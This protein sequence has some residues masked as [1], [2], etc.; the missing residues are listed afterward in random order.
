MACWNQSRNVY[1][2]EILLRNGYGAGSGCGQ[3]NQLASHNEGCLFV[4]FHL[5]EALSRKTAREWRKKKETVKGVRGTCLGGNYA[6][7][8]PG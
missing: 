6:T 4:F 8:V 3:E 5:T 2:G 1:V 7:A